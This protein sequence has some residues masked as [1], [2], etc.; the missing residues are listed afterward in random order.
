VEYLVI[1][2]YILTMAF[3]TLGDNSQKSMSRGFEGGFQD[4]EMPIHISNVKK[5]EA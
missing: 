2:T 4:K 3:Y 1:I 5:V